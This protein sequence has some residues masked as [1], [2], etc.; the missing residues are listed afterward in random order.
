MNLNL[1]ISLFTSIICFLS[2]SC[3]KDNIHLSKTHLEK[4]YYSDSIIEQKYSI[5]SYSY[6]IESDTV[7][8]FSFIALNL[9]SDFMIKTR[10]AFLEE[11]FRLDFAKQLDSALVFGIKENVKGKIRHINFEVWHNVNK[12]NAQKM[13]DSLNTVFDKPLYYKPPAEWQWFIYNDK[14]FFI[15]GYK[16]GVDSNLLR[17]IKLKYERDTLFLNYILSKVKKI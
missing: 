6:E 13:I 5:V 4:Q 1:G 3:K 17:E 11:R 16:A 10:M 14:V 8:A 12:S 9:S 7:P 2:I 15:D